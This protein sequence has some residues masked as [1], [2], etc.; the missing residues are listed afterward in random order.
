MIDER[1]QAIINAKANEIAH[2]IIGTDTDHRGDLL[3]AVA[4]RLQQEAQ[5][6]TAHALVTAA[7]Q[8]GYENQKVME[9]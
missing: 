2:L 7:R 6:Y 3:I 1:T 5:N 9:H 8:Y 4:A